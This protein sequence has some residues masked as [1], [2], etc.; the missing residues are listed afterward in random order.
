[1]PP[2]PQKHS[3]PQPVSD[4]LKESILALLRAKFYNSGDQELEAKCFAQDRK[5]LLA[6]VVLWPAAWLKGKEVTIHGE[7]YRKIFQTVFI[8]A[9][10][11]VTSKIHY[12]PAYLRQVIQEYFKC[13]GDEVYDEAKAVRNLAEHVLLIAGQARVAAPDP[14]AELA[15]AKRI[16]DV[17]KRKKTVINPP[18]KTQLSLWG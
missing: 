10:A 16:L 5:R 7:A 2:R 1:M 13:H 12:R 18:L 9:A 8:D 11:H 3:L 15:A 17:P 6:W 14:V 4:E